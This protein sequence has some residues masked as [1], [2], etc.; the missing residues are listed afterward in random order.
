MDEI[1][2]HFRHLHHFHHHHHHL[3]HNLSKSETFLDLRL[4]V[5]GNTCK[6]SKIPGRL[7]VRPN[8]RKFQGV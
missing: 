8:V 6:R 1:H 3:E 4:N 2:E 7:D 5:L